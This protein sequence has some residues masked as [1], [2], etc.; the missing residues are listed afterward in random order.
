LCN[1]YHLYTVAVFVLKKHFYHLINHNI[2]KQHF[3][4]G[5]A[6]GVARRVWFDHCKQP[7]FK[8]ILATHLPSQSYNLYASQGA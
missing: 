5:V 3:F 2:K 8:E 1:F 4:M 6:S 7:P